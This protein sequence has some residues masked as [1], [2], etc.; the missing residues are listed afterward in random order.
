MKKTWILL[1]V[2]VTLAGVLDF[3]LSALAEKPLYTLKFHYEQATTSPS[4]IYGHE[5]WAK[6]VGKA[7]HGRVAIQIFPGDTLFKTK[8]DV[9]D[10]VKAGLT[11]IAFMYAWAFSPQFDLID[12]LSVP[13]I[14]PNGEVASRTSWK[15][16]TMFPEIQKQWKDVKVLT[17]WDTD[18][19]IFETSKKMIKT[20]EDFK[21]MKIR[22]TGGMATEMMKLLGG[23]PVTI[24]MPQV[25]ENLQKGVI[26]GLTSPCEA[27]LGFRFYE[28]ATN[29][30]LVPTTCV[31][32]ELIMNKKSWER[33]PADIQQQIMSVSGEN[34]AIRY[35]GGVFDRAR[36]QLPMICKKNGYT[37]NTYTPPQSEIDR[38]TEVAGKPL[39]QQWVKTMEGRGYKSAAKIQKT[40]I[41]LI[42]EYK[43]G[44]MDTWKE[45]FPE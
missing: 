4:A 28:L 1:M 7:T 34:A 42:G 39:W 3:S 37:M 27:I 10:A 16:F 30:T 45:L 29:Y 11:D 33:L 17:V 13:F 5:A 35:G 40:A 25:Y 20:Q 9:V 36:E 8:T 23:T 21:G 12:S 18:P 38:W 32:Q 43:K 41:Q 15:L 2:V 22:M 31:S 14:A 24:P 26:D 44:K 6:A 19:Y